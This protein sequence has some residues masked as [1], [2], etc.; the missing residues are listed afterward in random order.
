MTKVRKWTTPDD[1]IALSVV[2]YYAVI[3]RPGPNW[4]SELQISRFEQRSQITRSQVVQ[5]AEYC[6]CFVVHFVFCLISC[7]FF[8]NGG[9]HALRVRVIIL[10][11]Q[12]GFVICLFVFL[13]RVDRLF[14]T[15]WHHGLVFKAVHVPSLLCWVGMIDDDSTRSTFAHATLICTFLTNWLTSMQPK[16]CLCLMKSCTTL[17]CESKAFN[18]KVCKPFKK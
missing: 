2:A 16:L 9:D 3:I 18:V 8:R 4:F 12:Y 7:A 6:M 17:L 1:L 10:L 15:S 13:W 5:W 14:V 11:R